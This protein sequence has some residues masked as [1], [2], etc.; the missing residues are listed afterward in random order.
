MKTYI[1]SIEFILG[2]MSV[3]IVEIDFG[4]IKT[5]LVPI[6]TNNTVL[7]KI[8]KMLEANRIDELARWFKDEYSLP[9]SKIT[10]SIGP[11]LYRW[12]S[13]YKYLQRKYKER[14]N[15]NNEN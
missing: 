3:H 9:H 5:I 8:R 11:E 15:N 10:I 1:I 13:H 7:M 14:G 6:I 12:L 4:K 2:T